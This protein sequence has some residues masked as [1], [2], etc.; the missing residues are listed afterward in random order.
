MLAHARSL[1]RFP[2]LPSISR[3][4]VFW[5]ISGM[6]NFSPGRPQFSSNPEKKSPACN[7]LKILKTLCHVYNCDYEGVMSV[8]HPFK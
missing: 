1:A 4:M 5:F 8:L 6:T 7:F 3:V 2:S